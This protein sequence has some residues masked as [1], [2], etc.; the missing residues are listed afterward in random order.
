VKILHVVPTYLPSRRYG[1]PI[2]A[3]HGLA[4]ALVARGHDVDVFTTNVDGDKNSDVPLGI[5]VDLDGV[6]VHYFPSPFRRLYW[7]PRLR[8]ELRGSIAKYDVAHLHSLFLYPTAAAA[9]EAQRSRVPYVISP[10]GMLVPELI[11][12]KS[13][14]TKTLWLRLIERGNFTGA[15]AIHFTTER[16]REDAQRTKMPV[17]A[18]FVVPNGIVLGGTAALPPPRDHDTILFLGRINWK[19]GIDRLIAALPHIDGARLV[20]AGN[21]E[22]NLTP[23]LVELAQH[24][25]VADRIEFIGAVSG[26]QKDDLL[27]R[28]TLL[29]LAS[30]SEN[31]GNVILE[32]MAAQT[33]VV[34][35]AEVGLAEEVR[36]ARAGIVVGSQPREIANAVNALLRDP[37]TRRSMGERGRHAVEAR[38][39]WPRVAAE[40]EAQY[41]R[42]LR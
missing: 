15:A 11:A 41:A 32:A 12:A 36:R 23:R 28:A 9:R 25:G 35:T 10:R 37:D 7:S 4:R 8:I 40:M 39:T 22:E 14:W 24:L 20:I 38:F 17:P 30:I 5:R 18:S 21:D 33:P 27:A 31:F 26:P 13:R 2:F 6:G 29:A 34:V 3:V 16:E 1:G 42:L 19:K